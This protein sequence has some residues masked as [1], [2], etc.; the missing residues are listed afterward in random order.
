MHLFLSQP[1]GVFNSLL[2]VLPLKVGVPFQDLLKSGPVGNLAHDDG[3]RNPHS[4]NARASSHD[5]RI[6][7]YT[8]KHRDYLLGYWSLGNTLIL[9]RSTI[10]GFKRQWNVLFKARRNR[11][12][13]DPVNQGINYVYGMLYGEVWRALVRVGLDPRTNTYEGKCFV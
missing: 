5:L 13:T 1:G 11:G 3:D 12:A 6:K 10:K 7:R 4:S 9:R 8:V 2:N